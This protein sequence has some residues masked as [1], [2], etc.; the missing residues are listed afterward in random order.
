MLKKNH[1]DARSAQCF[2]WRDSAGHEVDIVLEE[3]GRLV[4][5]E[6]KS[7]RT[8][9]SDFFDGLRRWGNLSGVKEGVLIYGGDE[10]YE[11][12]GFR[13]VPWNEVY[14]AL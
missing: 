11:R 1:N 2:F 10:S 14:D 9:A 13:V 3:G 12:E 6:I 7:G 5:A 4:P 8:V